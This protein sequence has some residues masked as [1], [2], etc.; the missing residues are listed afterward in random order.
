[1]D[2]HQLHDESTGNQGYQSTGYDDVPVGDKSFD[3]HDA[4][5]DQNPDIGRSQH[6]SVV[7]GSTGIGSSDSYN[8]D[9]VERMPK[10]AINWK[11]FFLPSLNS[12]IG[13]SIAPI[14]FY[15]LLA[16]GFF[17]IFIS[18]VQALIDGFRV[19]WAFAI[20]WTFPVASILAAISVVIHV[21]AMRLGYEV[22]MSIFVLR[23]RVTA[24]SN[25][26]Q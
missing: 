12:F 16:T 9:D 15:I 23:S 19:H 2:A 26:E 5:H 14:F 24:I 11:E 21:L 10:Q 20:F 22:V 13:V 17:L 18:Y 7:I 1:M 8:V 4:S 25:K 3:Y 6:H